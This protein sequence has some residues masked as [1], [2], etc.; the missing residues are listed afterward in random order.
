[1]GPGHPPPCAGLAGAAGRGGDPRFLRGG[2]PGRAG[3]LDDLDQ[4]PA[5][6]GSGPSRAL[7]GDDLPGG[8][9]PPPVDGARAP[10]LS[11]GPIAAGDL[12][13]GAGQGAERFPPQP[14]DVG[15]VRRALPHHLHERT[16]RLPQLHTG[17]QPVGGHPGSAQ[18]RAPLRQ[19]QL[20][21]DGL[22]LP[23]AAGG[24]PEHMA[25][26]SARVRPQGVLHL[27]RPVAHP[28]PRHLRAERRRSDPRLRAVRGPDGA[29][30][31]HP[32]DG[33]AVP[34]PE[35]EGGPS[36]AKGAAAASS[37]CARCTRS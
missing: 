6:V 20:S 36:T 29:H 19:R 11:A 32:V 10:G 25:V 37:P 22:R 8:A 7:P 12:L 28:A 5:G 4:A 27:H 17:S 33:Q 26:L 2:C 21:D 14:G 15:G 16:A 23:D 35:L 34:G 30:G 9:V 3:S 18:P 13:T 31:L 1:M 24:D